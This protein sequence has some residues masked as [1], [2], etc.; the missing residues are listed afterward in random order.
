MSGYHLCGYLDS[1]RPPERVEVDDPLAVL[2]TGREMAAR[3][4]VVFARADSHGRELA[5]FVGPNVLLNCE[6]PAA[7]NPLA[8]LVPHRVT[9]GSARGG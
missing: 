4:L 7:D 9:R 6:L 8:R 3:G 5:L 2:V 1:Q